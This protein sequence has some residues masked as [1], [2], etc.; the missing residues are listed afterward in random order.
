LQNIDDGQKL[1]DQQIFAYTNKLHF[2]KP[3]GKKDKSSVSSAGITLANV[4]S[5]LGEE[6]SDA[7]VDSNLRC[8]RQI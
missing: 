5:V 3:V 7:S 8:K 6:I 2:V 4:T 1:W